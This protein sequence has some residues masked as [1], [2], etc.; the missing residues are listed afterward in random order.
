MPTPLLLHTV[1]ELF[2]AG[3]RLLQYRRKGL[4]VDAQRAEAAAIQ[5]LASANKAALII[6]DNLALAL[7][8]GARGVHWGRDDTVPTLPLAVQINAARQQAA[9]VG[10][11]D[12]VVG[13]SCY[14]E[15]SR[16]ENAASA[17]ADYVAFGSMFAS[18]T[19]PSAATAP[20]SLVVQAKQQLETPVV[21]IGGVT[22]DNAPLLI[23]AGVDAVAVITDLFSTDDDNERITRVSSYQSLFA[24]R[25]H[26]LTPSP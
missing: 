11:N 21:A 26:K 3:V 22:R 6:N 9:A 8:V 25:A 18:Q 16:A 20:I 13:V 2:R 1:G 24:A 14:N 19:K 4:D 7:A 15:Y 5:A 10:I 23:D 17:G 12:F